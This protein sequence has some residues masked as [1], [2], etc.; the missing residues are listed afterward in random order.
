MAEVQQPEEELT[1]AQLENARLGYQAAISMWS[2]YGEGLWA[3]YSAMLVANSIVLAAVGLVYASQDPLPVL[4]WALPIVGLLLSVV[5]FLMTKRGTEYHIYFGLAARELEENFLAN[6]VKLRSRGASY[7]DGKPVT[8]QIGGAA[9]TL[10][11]SVW[12]RA[13][14]TRH[15]SYI[16]IA[17]FVAIYL[18][19]IV[20]NILLP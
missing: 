17:V 12:A 2:Y 20:Q 15:L 1:A 18:A 5:R 14:R 11:M 8:L 4:A 6:E 13:F 3:K 7:A 16:V 19:V 9:T 10:Q